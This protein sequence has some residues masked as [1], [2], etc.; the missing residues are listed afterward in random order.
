MWV[1]RKTS[2]PKRDQVIREWRRLHNKK[3][4]VLYSSL[5]INRVVKSGK[6]GVGQV[7]NVK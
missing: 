6:K 7:A 5:N 1:L 2:E 4:R 3:P